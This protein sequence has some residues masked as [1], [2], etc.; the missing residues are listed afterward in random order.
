MPSQTSFSGGRGGGGLGWERFLDGL[1]QG[2]L[3]SYTLLIGLAV[4]ATVA[5]WAGTNV[6]KKD[7]RR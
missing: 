1:Q 7:T 6:T 5:I 2:R 3:S 4:I